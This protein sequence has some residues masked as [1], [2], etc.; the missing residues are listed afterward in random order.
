M[1]LG[2]LFVKRHPLTLIMPY[3]ASPRVAVPGR[4]R[5]ACVDRGPCSRTRRLAQHAD[6][7]NSNQDA[8]RLIRQVQRA[9]R[10][11]LAQQRYGH[12]QCNRPTELPKKHTGHHCRDRHGDVREEGRH[13]GHEQDRR[14]G[15]E[16]TEPERSA[17]GRRESTARLAFRAQHRD[18]PQHPDREGQE[19]KPRGQR[20]PCRVRPGG[21]SR[22]SADGQDRVEEVDGRHA[23]PGREPCQQSRGERALDAKHA[24]GADR[25]GDG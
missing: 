3:H 17:I 25:C 15:V 13:R 2:G 12:T 11:P 21:E 1:T 18:V 16:E 19:H 8:G 24:H 7:Q 4:D 14:E 6:R 20:Q 10:H 9:K 23:E 5:S 22:S